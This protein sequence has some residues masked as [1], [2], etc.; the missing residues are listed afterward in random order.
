[1]STRLLDPVFTL[2]E[3][4]A[5]I[6][7]ESRVTCTV[8]GGSRMVAHGA[9][10]VVHCNVCYSCYAPV[11]VAWRSIV[12]ASDELRATGIVSLL[13]GEST[14]VLCLSCFRLE[15]LVVVRQLQHIG[16]V[17]CNYGEGIR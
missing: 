14:L 13:T 9:P 2:S 16:L 7:A 17:H 4:E 6:L 15:K 8:V 1:M 3:K 5:Q 12:R 11:Q 10:D